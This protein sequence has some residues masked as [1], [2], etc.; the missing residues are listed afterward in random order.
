[1]KKM[2][3]FLR[4]IL[5][6]ILFILFFNVLASNAQDI[7]FTQF[8]NSPGN[9]NPA[10]TGLFNGSQRFTLQNK[11]QWHSVTTPFK[12]I[13]ASYDLALKKR[14]L[15]H[16]IFGGGI[17]INRDQAG[18][19]K[20]GTS[21]ANLAFSYIR[22]LNNA[23]NQ[24]LSFGVQAGIAQRTI[25]YSKLSFDSQYDGTSYNPSLSNNE[26]FSKSNFFFADFSAGAYW[27]YFRRKELEFNGGIAL[28]HINKPKQSLFGNND[29]TLD[30]KFVF[31]GGSKIGYKG[32][33]RL[34][35]GFLVLHQGPYNE[36][37][38]GSILKM[39]KNKN[40][41]DY[42]A[43]QAGLYYRVGDAFNL[44]VGIDYLDF[45][46]GVS[47]DINV[48]GL[49]PASHAKGGFEISLIYI[50]DRN[51][52]TYVRKIPCPIF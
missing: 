11:T 22:A 25:D 23:N 45:S 44:I 38:V 8:Y 20:F 17:I 37:D 49:I 5:N 15:R 19:S 4:K 13:S 27:S 32:N 35:P 21:Q 42:L 52:K 2:E 31:H 34:M 30:R 28:F 40:E 10:L 51:K 1:M 29:I 12:T 18:D 6:I 24:F 26:Q 7:H 16:D 47:Y 36:V 14:Y 9:L 43:L 39:I 48:S 46:L 50:A 33:I 3:C 41:A